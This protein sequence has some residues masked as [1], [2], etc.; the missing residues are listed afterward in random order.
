VQA[1]WPK[2]VKAVFGA[3]HK[4]AVMLRLLLDV[5][6]R[7]VRVPKPEVHAFLAQLPAF[8]PQLAMWMSPASSAE[9]KENL[10]SLLKR[11]VRLDA[12]YVAAAGDKFSIVREAFVVFLARD[13]PLAFKTEALDLLS[14]MLA[15]PPAT[16]GPVRE[17]LYEMV[18][19]DFP[20][21]SRDLPQS[22]AAYTE[23]IACLDKL[24][25]ALVDSRSLVLL[26]ALYPIL[27]E[28]DHACVGAA[29]G[30]DAP[31]PFFF[32]SRY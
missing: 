32:F 29:G 17:R 15:L 25:Q 8:L 20:L 26:D 14:F 12:E 16:L 5:L 13:T 9:Q 18:I 2:F 3:L 7:L 30:D 6:D 22:S 19:N 23:Y 21:R 4:S 11:V 27:R 1:H 10:L 24:L 28:P 31:S